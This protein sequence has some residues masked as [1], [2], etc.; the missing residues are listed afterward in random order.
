VSLEDKKPTTPEA[1]TQPAQAPRVPQD[2]RE[3][4]P[5]PRKPARLRREPGG[6][7]NA[8]L[9]RLSDEE[10]AQI[11]DRAAAHG[12]SV[13]RFMLESSLAESPDSLARRRMLAAEFLG[14][15][16]LVARLGAELD[17]LVEATRSGQSP[18]GLE[19]AVRAVS[20]AAARLEA[21]VARLDEGRS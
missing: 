15:R 5:A 9:V 3:S 11:C 20:E 7:P 1:Q 10:K 18:P 17:E 19:S 4:P 8:V 2:R 12:V 21:A 6:R 14:A 13:P 16:R